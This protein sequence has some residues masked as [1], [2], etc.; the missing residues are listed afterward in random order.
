MEMFTMQ[1]PFSNYNSKLQ[2]RANKLRKNMTKAEACLWKYAIKANKLGWPFR[3]Q[4]PIDQ[5]IVDFVCLTLKLIIEVDGESHTNENIYENDLKRQKYLEN[6]GYTFLRFT[7]DE[8][9]KEMNGVIEV[10]KISLK[11]LEKYLT[12]DNEDKLRFEKP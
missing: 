10:I 2:K 12:L 11:E 6:L 1:K 9:L 8:V 4:R 3:R 7:D 5:Y